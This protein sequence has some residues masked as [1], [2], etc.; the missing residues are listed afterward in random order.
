MNSENLKIIS[1]SN[2]NG[3]FVKFSEIFQKI[4]DKSPNFDLVI[5]LGSVFNIHKDF[6]Q[7]KELEKFSTK[8]L[9]LDDSEIGVVTKH[10]FGN[11][12]YTM[13]EK[14]TILGRSGVLYFKDLRIA[15]LNGKENKKFLSEDE[16]YKYTSFF[17]SRDDVENLT[18][19]NKNNIDITSF[20]SSNVKT[21]F[22]LTNC[23]PS[24]IFNE[25]KQ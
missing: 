6:S 1:F 16:K 22:L 4:L 7:V 3:D 18:D 25:M 15:Y 19:F 9:I 5:L 8:F 17:F 11:E 13:S 14:V 23:I 2:I 10:K 20:T 12:N 21:D 24:I